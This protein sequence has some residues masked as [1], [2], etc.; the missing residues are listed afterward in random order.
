[1]FAQSGT[2]FLTHFLAQSRSPVILQPDG[3]VLLFTGVVSLGVGVLFG[4]IPALRLSRLDLVAIIKNQGGGVAGP[5]RGRL[6]PLLIVAQVALSV[7]LL[8][9]AGLFAR[10]LHNLRTVDF[11]FNRENLLS[12]SVGSERW[13][14]APAEMNILLK[15][16]LTE[17]EAKPGVQGISVG[18]AGLLTGNGI[19]MDFA[20]DGYVPAP[21]EEMLA[22]AVLAGPRFFETL[23]VPLLRGRE[24]TSADEPA[25]NGADTHARVAILGE[26]MARRYF[27]NADPIGRHIVLDGREKVQLEIVGVAK[28]TKYSR[29][30][31]DQTPLEFYIP[32]FGS[33]IRMPPTFYL[34]TDQSAAALAPEIH[35]IVAQVEPRL[36]IRDLLP[37]DEVID[38]LLVR[39]RIITQLVGFFSLF[40]LLLAC[41]GIYGI[42]SLRVAQRTREIGVRMALGATF[43]TV[44]AMVIRQGLLLVVAGGIAGVCAALMATRFVATLLYG[45]TPADPFT[46]ATVVGVLLGVA[47]TACWLPARRAARVDPMV[48]LRTD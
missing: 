27:G 9:G 43:H 15:R 6:Q 45:V 38:R 10:T 3:R 26:T 41:L 8:A 14:P 30:L 21:G 12:F 1:V 36:M 33:G 11:G 40:A 39:E 28:E 20:A 31:R 2:S 47:M 13:R 18:G 48:A 32:Y 5:A 23:R 7:M 16:L 17:L 19:T 25:P 29:N 22:R 24:F 44:V 35:R 4:L 42:L 34:R 46:F 37:M